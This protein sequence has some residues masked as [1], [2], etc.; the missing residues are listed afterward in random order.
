[1]KGFDKAGRVLEFD[2]ITERLA[3]LAAT[4]GAAEAL[5]SLQPAD[6]GASVNRLLDQTA[7]ARAMMTVKSQP[8]FGRA[9][10]ITPHIERAVKGATLTTREL[11]DVASLLR[12]V[13]ALK[14]Y[15][16]GGG[17]GSLHDFFR[18]LTENNFLEKSI[19]GAIAAED[20]LSDNASDEL[21]SIRRSIRKCESAVRDGLA[22]YTTGSYAKYLQ[23]G[24][25][26]VRNGRFVIPVKAEYKGEIKGIVHDTSSSGGTLFVEPLDI[27][28]LNNRISEL[29]GREKHE[30]DRI[31]AEL[32]ASVASFADDLRLN[33]RVL[34]DLAVIFAKAQYSFEINGIRP[35]VRP[36]G[37]VIR[38]KNARHP[39]IDKETVVPITVEFGGETDALVITGPNTGGKTVTLKTIG[40]MALMAQSGLFLPCDDGSTLPVFSAVLPDIGDEQSIEQSLSTFSS[41]MVN[42]V[43]ILDVCDR[44]T[45]VL[46]DELGAGT[47]PIEGAALAVA[48]LEHVRSLGALVA[49]TTHYAE[50]KTYAMENER[51]RNASCEFDVDTLKPTY[52]LIIGLPGKSNAF[53]ISQRL[54]IPASIIEEAKRCMSAERVQ[55]EDMLSRLESAESTLEKEKRA[56]EKQRAEAE[57]L[58]SETRR[59]L[60]AER[61]Q[62]QREL[63]AAQDAA[64][65]ILSNARESANY[66]FNELNELKKKQDRESLAKV[67]EESRRSVKEALGSAD[68]RLPDADETEDGYTPPRPFAH[69]DTVSVASLGGV[70]GTITRLEPPN[71]YV[72]AGAGNVKVKLADLRLVQGAKPKKEQKKASF[73]R[74]NGNAAVRNELDLRGQYGDDAWFMADRFIDSAVMAGYET[75]TLIHGKGT[76]A[77]RAALWQHLKNDRRVVSYRSGRYGEGD[78]GVTV[79]EL[80]K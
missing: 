12:T 23:E 78:L 41:H 66:V 60:E 58:L 49:A 79:C 1:M 9:K 19:S 39:L 74:A 54:G 71:A 72:Q 32:S 10:N 76:G 28:E 65:R 35:A 13:G 75:V 50:L 30:I 77:L 64:A 15:G 44:D 57:R 67:L 5:R 11:L 26:T 20:M 47:D 3:S 37:R 42:I 18:L 61:E 40:L 31:L 27:L 17:A 55:F 46:F 70:Q 29:H 16:A 24:L 43:S 80:K 53:A 62:A 63:K 51:V 22:R 7:D 48:I 33:Y 2:R 4:E 68:I 45:L 36:D 34:T 56:A 6:D 38:L 69:G 52:R 59:Q 14:K 73:T 21:F 25:V 8:P